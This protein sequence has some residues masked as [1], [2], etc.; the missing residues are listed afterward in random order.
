MAAVRPNLETFSIKIQE[1]DYGEWLVRLLCK[2]LAFFSSFL[3]NLPLAYSSTG[4]F[5]KLD[6][7]SLMCCVTF[8]HSAFIPLHETQIMTATF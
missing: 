5:L 2:P 7:T 3:C 6:I 4:E 1:K 8:S